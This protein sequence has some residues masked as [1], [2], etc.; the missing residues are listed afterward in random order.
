LVLRRLRGFKEGVSLK[1]AFFFGRE[2]TANWWLS[3]GKPKGSLGGLHL[4]ERD[5]FF[6]IPKKRVGWP[7][8]TF[9]IFSH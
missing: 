9:L 7:T 2:L 6:D 5:P 1:T 4:K 8:K 3:Q